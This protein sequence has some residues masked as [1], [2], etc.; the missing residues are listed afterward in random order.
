MFREFGYGVFCFIAAMLGMFIGVSLFMPTNR[1][2]A[3]EARMPFVWA[4]FGAI[5][6]GIAWLWWRHAITKHEAT[7]GGKPKS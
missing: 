2:A 1:S 4:V 7:P 5:A 6:G 3:I